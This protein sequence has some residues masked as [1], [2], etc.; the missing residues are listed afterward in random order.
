MGSYTN[1]KRPKPVDKCKTKNQLKRIL[2]LN[3][4]PKDI[5]SYVDV[6]KLNELWVS[7]IRKIVNFD[8]LRKRG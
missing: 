4:P 1:K 7:Y 6:L 3:R 5:L 2:R 8:D